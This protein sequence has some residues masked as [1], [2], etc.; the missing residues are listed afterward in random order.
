[1]GC[2][3]S[4]ATGG[5]RTRAT[6]DKSRLVSIEEMVRSQ[7]AS[8]DTALQQRPRAHGLH[9]KGDRAALASPDQSPMSGGD[10]DPRTP[11]TP[12][13]PVAVQLNRQASSIR[14]GDP[15]DSAVQLT[16]QERIAMEIHRLSRCVRDASDSGALSASVTPQG[17][18]SGSD[19][20]VSCT[21]DVVAQVPT[22]KMTARATASQTLVSGWIASSSFA[23]PVNNQH[24]PRSDS[25]LP[26]DDGRGGKSQNGDV[27]SGGDNDDDSPPPPPEP[28][29]HPRTTVH[30]YVSPARN[31]RQMNAAHSSDVHNGMY[32]SN[33]ELH[34]EGNGDDGDDRSIELIPIVSASSPSSSRRA[35]MSHAL[36]DA[37]LT[38][39]R[40]G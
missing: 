21:A 27:R 37:E 31:L 13:C 29:Y 25:W 14:F 24:C 18:A 8:F 5:R 17:V 10:G 9:T 19:E 39:I 23:L 11:T 12:V 4:T 3:S 35:R 22:A 36:L 16:A 30:T 26:I 7:V 15:A 32:S 40:R 1:M 20:P 2:G 33:D 34:T 28:E 38:A 6:R